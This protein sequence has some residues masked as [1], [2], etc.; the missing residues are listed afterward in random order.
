MANKLIAMVLGL[1]IL[2]TMPLV[3]AEENE[4]IIIDSNITPIDEKEAKLILSPLG[5]EVRM[6]Q[7]EKSI[8]RNVLSGEVVLNTLKTNHPD[9]DLIESEKTLNTLEMLL[10]EVKN[11]NTQEDKNVLVQTFVELKKEARTLS[12]QF[13]TQTKGFIDSNDRTQIMLK[14][15]E[16]DSNYLTEIK[17]KAQE[18][19]REYNAL[20]VKQHLEALGEN[21]DSL[22]EDINRGVANLTQT[23]E[24]LMEKFGELND[25]N[26]KQIATKTRNEGIQKTI[27]NKKIMEQTKPELAQKIM[28]KIQTRTNDMNNWMQQKGIQ[29]P[30]TP[31][32][33]LNRIE[34]AISNTHG[35]NSTKDTQ[36]N[37]GGKQ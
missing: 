8:T 17:N 28:N 34:E 27:E 9:Y 35:V 30:N 24:K 3:L 16:I 2:T 18:R 14:I 31:S 4:G 6:I 12:T 13:K 5:A 11:T 33:R 21:E 37:G 26:K 15:K 22:I 23:R 1:L 29:L 25:A 32:N 7:L 10:E 36:P 20:R 19:I